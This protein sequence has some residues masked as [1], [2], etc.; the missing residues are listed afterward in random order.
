MCCVQRNMVLYLVTTRCIVSMR[1]EYL[2][3]IPQPSASTYMSVD[4]AIYTSTV[5]TCEYAV[6]Y[7]HILC[8]PHQMLYSKECC[9]Q[10]VRDSTCLWTLEPH[11]FF[12]LANQHQKPLAVVQTDNLL[13][14]F[15][16]DSATTTSICLCLCVGGMEQL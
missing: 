6:L 4:C 3:W 7:A 5:A 8:T 9:L 16:H 2:I 15:L 14:S 11:V 10:V 13:A 1:S 12:L